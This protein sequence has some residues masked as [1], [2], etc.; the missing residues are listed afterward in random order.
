MP[1][2]RRNFIKLFG[3]SLG[4][5][6]LARCQR[7]ATPEPTYPITCYEPTAAPWPTDPS[8]P[9][10]LPVRARLRLCWL[11]FSELAQNTSDGANTSIDGEN[12]L[13][14]QMIAEHRMVLD[15][16]FA[17]GDITPA[18]ADLV[19]EAYSAAIYHIWRSSALMTCYDL[20]FPDYTPASA[21]NLVRQ[22]EILNQVTAGSTIA[23]DTLAKARAALEHDLAFYAL[24]DEDIRALY[25]QLVVEYGDP[26]DSMPTFEELELTLTAD[27]KAAAQFLIDVLMAN[28]LGSA[29]PHFGEGSGEG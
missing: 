16:L 9:E 20:A 14:K 6:L 7:T 11:R 10:S 28:D 4:S 19:Q 13:G 29:P 25:D 3:I 12:K 23:P 5:L 27:A 15:E 17:A 24:T 2:P 18:I 1:V 26:E 8:T 21:E 22:T